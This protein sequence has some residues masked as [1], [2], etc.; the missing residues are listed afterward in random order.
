MY[1]VAAAA[2]NV[3]LQYDPDNLEAPDFNPTFALTMS[4]IRFA[5]VI[6]SLLFLFARM[7]TRG[8][9]R[10]PGTCIETMFVVPSGSHHV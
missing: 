3:S 5:A 10:P 4:F 9:K 7:D 1:V 8:M 2:S 6:P